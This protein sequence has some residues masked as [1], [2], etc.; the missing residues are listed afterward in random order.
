M[1][2][3]K[4][5]DFKKI[6][7]AALTASIVLA[8]LASQAAPPDHAPAYGYR[9]KADKK[10][11][12][13][14]RK[15]AKKANKGIRDRNGD[16]YDDR[17]TNSDGN[18]DED[19][20]DY[21][22]T[23]D[24]QNQNDDNFDDNYNGGYNNGRYNNVG[25]FTTLSGVVTND[26]NGNS[27]EMRA[28]NGQIVRVDLNVTEP[29]A[30]QR[31]SR[32]RVYGRLTN[33]TMRR[34]TV[35]VLSNDYNNGGYN[36]GYGNGGHANQRVTLRGVVTRDLAGRRF[37]MRQGSTLYY[38][39]LTRN[40]PR[41]LSVGD[42]VEISGRRI[43]NNTIQADTL[44]LLQD[45]NGNND[46]RINVNFPGRVLNVSNRRNL[47]VCGN[48]GTTYMV[49]SNS[50]FDSRISAGDRVRIVGT[51][52]KG[53][54]NIT[55]SRVE[56][57]DD[58]GNTNNGENYNNGDRIDIRGTVR[59]SQSQLFVGRVLTVDGDDGQTYKVRTGDRSFQRGDTVRVRGTLNN[60]FVTNASINRL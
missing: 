16:G 50:D 43:K 40:E 36:N 30:L 7:L 9:N 22:N 35:A 59:S 13:A 11:D 34:A 41:R 58:N 15:A 3:T 37:E 18:I 42:R 10:A 28:D 32:V 29:N 52:F 27:F 14:E 55:A 4:T 33:N 2:I 17:D 24:Y 23:P 45:N 47:T 53:S 26:L 21:R 48:N 39:T 57:R 51:G 20:A 19:D 49:R 8:P 54:R 12:K 44:R 38:V 25:A 6:V 1:F 5:P 46:N 56:L 31:G 60:G